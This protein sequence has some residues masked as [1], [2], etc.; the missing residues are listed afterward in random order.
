S[1]RPA[2]NAT[3]FNWVITSPPYYGMRTYIPD[4]WLRN[5]FVGGSEVVDYS[6]D[7]QVFHSSPECFSD[8]LRK[9]WRNA[10]K[11]CADDATM[12]VRFGGIADR[13]ADPIGI[14]KDSLRNSGWRIK[15]IKDAGTAA[16]GKRQADTFLRQKS[17]SLSEYDVWASK[18]K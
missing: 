10:A 15:T 14:I 13:Q 18:Y 8:D 9:V 4:Q 12:V 11:V 2:K 17:S 6:T 5:W 7:G 1:L 3:P 16:R